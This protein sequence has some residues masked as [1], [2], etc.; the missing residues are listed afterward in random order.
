MTESWHI[1]MRDG[2]HERVT[3]HMNEACHV[4]YGWVT[5]R[6]NESRHMWMSHVL[7]E[8]VTLHTN[9]SRAVWMS[10]VPCEWVMS[11]IN[12]WA[13]S[14]MNESCHICH[15]WM[16]HVTYKRVMSHMNECR[17]IIYEWVWMS[18]VIYMNEK[19]HTWTSAC[20]SSHVQARCRAH[21]EV[22]SPMNEVASHMNE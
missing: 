7:Y 2:T 1:W 17:Y 12:V 21:V 3:S 22:T 13:M 20:T 8:W 14:Y 6:M 9:E 18:Q 19:C 4:T 10:H 5:H 16:R 15:I 11:H